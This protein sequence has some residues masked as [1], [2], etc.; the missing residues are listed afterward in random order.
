MPISVVVFVF[1]LISFTAVAIV[2]RRFTSSTGC[3]RV[4]ELHSRSPPS[5][6]QISSSSSTSSQ[7]SPWARPIHQVFPDQQVD[8]VGNKHRQ[9]QELSLYSSAAPKG[10]RKPHCSHID[11]YSSAA[12]NLSRLTL[13]RNTN[14]TSGIMHKEV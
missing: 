13:R 12:P 2:S 7:A 8:E 11:M 10:A 3:E 1:S 5:S 14:T 4:P 9:Q 6:P